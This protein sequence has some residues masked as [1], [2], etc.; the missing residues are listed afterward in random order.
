MSNPSFN[1]LLGPISSL[2]QYYDYILNDDIKFNSIKEKYPEIQNLLESSRNDRACSCRK[3]VIDYLN[4]K[5]NLPEDHMFLYSILREEI[6]TD[7]VNEEANSDHVHENS[8]DLN[9]DR[10]TSSTLSDGTTIEYFN[11]NLTKVHKVQ[12]G[13]EN[14]KKFITDMRSK[15]IFT[16]F[17]VIDKGDYLEVY[18]M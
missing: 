3:T 10:V 16:N 6:I 5:L 15:I 9:E 11:E 13:D 18:F 7:R 4:I 1:Q 8:S 17:S 12:K 2:D 14:W